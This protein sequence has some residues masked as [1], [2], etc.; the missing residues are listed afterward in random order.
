MD[1]NRQIK[2]GS[3]TKA[4]AAGAEEASR[5]F[6]GILEMTKFDVS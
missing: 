4:I 3:L 1:I 6:A 2:P 5:N